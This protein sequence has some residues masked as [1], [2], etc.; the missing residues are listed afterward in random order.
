MRF[1]LNFDRIFG[2]ERATPGILYARVVLASFRLSILIS[3]SGGCYVFIAQFIARLLLFS[4]SLFLSF[5]S[6]GITARTSLHS[7][8]GKYLNRSDA[9]HLLFMSLIYSAETMKL[10]FPRFLDGQSAR[11]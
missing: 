2:K 11:V 1:F 6:P 4:P 3:R 9:S 10:K 8:A 5:F 7:A